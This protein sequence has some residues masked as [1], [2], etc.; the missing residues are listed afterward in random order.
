MKSGN[1]NFLEPTGPL[2]ACNGTDLLYF[3]YLPVSGSFPFNAYNIYDKGT[4]ILYMY[5]LHVLSKSVIYK[6]LINIYSCLYNLPRRHRK[7]VEL[8]VCSFFNLGPRW[9]WVVNATPLSLFSLYCI[10]GWVGHRV[11]VDGCG[12]ICPPRRPQRNSIPGLSSR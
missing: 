1:V 5:I 8:G 3:I 2:Q 7:T 9:V 12:K 6:F 4:A 11:S 10:V